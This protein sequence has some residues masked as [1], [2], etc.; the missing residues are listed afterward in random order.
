[1][2]SGVD[3]LAFS[4][5]LVS[6][7]SPPL[8]V[9]V[10]KKS[11]V[12]DSRTQSRYLSVGRCGEDKPVC[13]LGNKATYHLGFSARH[14]PPTARRAFADF[15]VQQ[16]TWIEREKYFRTWISP[17][18]F[19]VISAIPVVVQADHRIIGGKPG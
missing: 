6:V 16:V 11:E 2:F 18:A 9:L 1:L 17:A 4:I 19:E 3:Q 14:N 10:A 15:C 5:S 7:P 8:L 13:M 12:D